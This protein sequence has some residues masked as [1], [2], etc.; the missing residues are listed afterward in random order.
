MRGH[1]APRDTKN[2]LRPHR[3]QQLHWPAA[4]S[5]PCTRTWCMYSFAGTWPSNNT[6][7]D[8]VLVGA[9]HYSGSLLHDH[10]TS[11]TACTATTGRTGA[12]RCACNAL[13]QDYDQLENRHI[14]S[15]M[16]STAR[17]WQLCSAGC[18]RLWVDRAL[19]RSG[20]ASASESRQLG[21]IGQPLFMPQP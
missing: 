1:C 5:S 21:P 20:S 8:L 6:V 14:H 18:S 2:T 9:R 4:S 19:Q 12:V 3:A 17:D 10:P 11:H 7:T 13:H 16:I 15:H